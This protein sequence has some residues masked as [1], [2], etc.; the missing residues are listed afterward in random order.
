MSEFLLFQFLNTP[1]LTHN[2]S[3]ALLDAKLTS[4]PVGDSH[5]TTPPQQRKIH[6]DPD[7]RYEGVGVCI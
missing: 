2:T 3:L 1:S 6:V 5:H 7:Q 4:T